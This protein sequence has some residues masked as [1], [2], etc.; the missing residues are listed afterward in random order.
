MLSQLHFTATVQL[1]TNLHIGTGETALLG[2]LR[3]G[4]PLMDDANPEVSVIF[5][6][7]KQ[8]P[9]I[10]ATAQKGALRKAIQA[11]KGEKEANRLFGEVKDTEWIRDSRGERPAEDKGAAGTVWLRMARRTEAPLH[12]GQQPF[13]DHYKESC[14]SAHVAI[15]RKTGTAADQK[16]FYVEEVPERAEFELRGVVIGELESAKSDLSIALSPLAAA[17][18]LAVGADQR[19]GSGRLFLQG[20]ANCTHRW[21]NAETGNIE[22]GA[23]FEHEIEPP[24]SAAT[25]SVRTLILTCEGPYLTIDPS[26]GRSGNEIRAAKRSDSAPLMPASSFMGCLRTRA[27]WLAE[28]EASKRGITPAEPLDQPDRSPEGWQRPSEL[29][30]VERLFGVSGWRGLLSVVSLVSLGDCSIDNIPSVSIDRFTG[31][32]LDSA[33][34][35]IEAF[36]GSQFKVTLALENRGAWPNESDKKLFDELMKDIVEEKSGDVFLIGHAVNRG[37]GWF[38]ASMERQA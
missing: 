12:P 32:F 25:G 23:L 24:A 15:E 38:S 17:E 30:S 20:P 16:L 4:A 6:D 22:T 27:A 21:F 18:G 36:V 14:I 34:F 9:A 13:W 2:G 11:A 10:P 3:P 7:E 26:Q 33:L 5:R 37:F 19:F 28:V 35:S 1:K 31:G 29:S 8:A